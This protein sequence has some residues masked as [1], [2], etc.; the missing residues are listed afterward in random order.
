MGLFHSRADS[1]L[2]HIKW[3]LAQRE[4]DRPIPEVLVNP[5]SSVTYTFPRRPLSPP[6][7]VPTW[8]NELMD[9]ITSRREKIQPDDDINSTR[10]AI[11]TG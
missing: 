3:R 8:H 6:K 10:C 9:K 7:K 4:N 11:F 1:E 2:E 5:L